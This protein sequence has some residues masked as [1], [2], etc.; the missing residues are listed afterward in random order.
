MSRQDAAAGSVGLLLFGIGL[1]L[2][3]SPLTL[4]WAQRSG[5]WY[6]PFAIWAGFILLV[7]LLNGRRRRNDL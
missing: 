4:W 2:F 3:A 7:G 5:P 6:L 1:L